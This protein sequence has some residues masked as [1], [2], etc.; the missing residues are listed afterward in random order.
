MEQ[1]VEQENFIIEEALKKGHKIVAIARDPDKLKEYGIEIIQ[2]TPY[3]YD[4][5]DKALTGCDA[6]IN[7]LNVS[8]KSDNPWATL[9]SPKDLISKSA[10]QCDKGYGKNRH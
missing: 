8:R 9:A 5:M 3:D 10:L 2:G 6:V 1:Q 7:T 4:T